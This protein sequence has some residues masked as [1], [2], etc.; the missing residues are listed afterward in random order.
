MENLCDLHFL[1]VG[2]TNVS[3]LNGYVENVCDETTHKSIVRK[4]N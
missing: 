2:Q 4:E 1:V 3:S